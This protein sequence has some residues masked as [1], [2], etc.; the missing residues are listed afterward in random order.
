M[1]FWRIDDNRA[2]ARHQISG[3][4]RPVSLF[5]NA[6]MSPCM[7]GGMQHP[8]SPA[9]FALQIERF[10]LLERAIDFD[11][12]LK[13]FLRDRM[14]RNLH[15]AFFLKMVRTTHVVAMQVRQ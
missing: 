1:P 7:S 9:R 5:K 13:I 15:A 3:D 4:Q 12:S 14:R 10:V 8:K 2:Q 6:N 11:E